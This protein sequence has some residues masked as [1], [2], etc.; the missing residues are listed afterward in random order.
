[1]GFEIDELYQFENALMNFTNVEFPKE[2]E[3]EILELSNSFLQ[4]LKNKSSSV[5][6]EHST[7]EESLANNWKVG[8]LV[9]DDNEYYI[10]VFNNSPYAEDIEYG[11]RSKLEKIKNGEKYK[12][13]NKMVFIPGRHMLKVSTEQLSKELPEHLSEWLDETIKELSL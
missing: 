13:N 6:Y 9:R 2:L 8:N 7:S 10:E 1:M 3:K 11:Y 12:S 5:N 4:S